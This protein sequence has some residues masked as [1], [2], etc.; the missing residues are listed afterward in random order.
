MARHLP[1]DLANEQPFRLAAV[2]VVP[3]ACE[4]VGNGQVQALEP[5]IMQV[6][7]VLARA[8]GNV[9]SRADLIDRCWG[10]RIVGENAVNRVMSRIRNLAETMGAGSFRLETITKVGYRLTLTGPGEHPAN[11]RLSAETP[12]SQN[13]GTDVA[14]AAVA[15]PTERFGR[16][17][18]I[19]GGLAAVAI[20][21]AG[22][23]WIDRRRPAEP[24]RQA[25]LLYT[26]GKEAQSQLLQSQSMQSVAY[27]QEAV[28][29]DPSYADAWGA[30]AMGYANLA[31][32]ADDVEQ[33]ALAQRLT[34]AATRALE[35]D[36]GNEDADVA[37][38]LI[39]PHF[40]H[41]AK[42]EQDCREGLR[43]HPENVRLQGKIPRVMCDTGR[44]REGAEGFEQLVRAEPYRPALHNQLVLALWSDGRIEEAGQAIDDAV[45]LWP[46]HPVIRATQ[47]EFLALT[48]QPAA[49]VQMLGP[50]ASALAERS[51][52]ATNPRFLV[53]RALATR[54]PADVE[55]AVKALGRALRDDT[56]GISSASQLL[57]ALGEVERLFALLSD[58]YLGPRANSLESRRPPV[59][60]ARRETDI[61]FTAI[62]APL[63]KDARFAAMTGAIGLDAY[64]KA[65]NSLPD[66]RR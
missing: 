40:R 22:W 23:L 51:P 59:R 20:S 6:L 3:A 58:Y 39:T 42:V 60:L 15:P 12:N 7:V 47:F 48:G 62:M 53:S 4:M 44:W 52:S 14:S 38:I 29:L 1:I 56:I 27:L 17:Q 37:R 8:D 33:E 18:A 11:Q 16:R 50:P 19:A 30:L 5:R 66:W 2:L 63:R 35:L 26:K 13:A 64:W 61:L 10:G 57:A 24:S 49:A 31:E 65:T 55:T 41:W 34:A 32:M 25:R 28:R 9:V 54:N 45:D 21:G 43:R 46:E 36:P